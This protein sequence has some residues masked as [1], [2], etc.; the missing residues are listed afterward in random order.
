[1]RRILLRW[2]A[3]QDDEELRTRARKTVEE[4]I[5]FY[6]HL[7]AYI[8][9]NLMFIALWWFGGGG[10]P[11]FMFV[12][13]GWGIGIA[14]HYFGAFYGDAYIEERAEEEYRRLKQER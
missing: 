10:F 9:V 6:M 8:L 1:M 5:G 12:L 3:V 14:A 2:I 4:R 13:F 7:A 11:W